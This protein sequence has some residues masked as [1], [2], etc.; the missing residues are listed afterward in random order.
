MSTNVVTISGNAG[1][2]AKLVQTQSGV[3][4]AEF[5]LA[6]TRYKLG[7]NGEKTAVT[8]WIPVKLFNKA[9]DRAGS[10]VT[11]GTRL[12]VTGR[13]EEES[14]IDRNTNQKRSRLVVIADSFE[15]IGGAKATAEKA[16]AEPVGQPV[17]QA[18]GQD[19]QDSEEIPF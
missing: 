2:D 8:S 5:S 15:L 1:A 16:Q 13:L 7:Q 9:A 10:Q 6:S 12:I 14:W 11:K 3:S 18:V 4:I 19:Y 17:A